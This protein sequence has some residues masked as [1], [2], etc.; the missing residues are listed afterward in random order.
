M[1]VLQNHVI[2]HLY[3]YYNN[4]N[5]N[6]IIIIIV[7][8]VTLKKKKKKKKKKIKIN[9]YFNILLYFSVK[10]KI[11]IFKMKNNNKIMNT[12]INHELLACK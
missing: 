1:F 2:I 4:N 10:F 5:N 3:R 11:I 12:S 6:N 9:I 8:V 7:V